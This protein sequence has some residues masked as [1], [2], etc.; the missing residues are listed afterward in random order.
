MIRKAIIGGAQKPMAAVER[1]SVARTLALLFGFGGLLLLF[2]VLLPPAGSGNR[3][4]AALVAVALLALIV[5]ACLTISRDRTPFWLMAVAPALGSLLVGAV[6][7]F[8]GHG[9]AEAYAL[10]F[11]WVVIAAATFL[12][13]GATALHGAF[14]V[15]V[16]DVAVR[17]A[18]PHATPSA[19]SLA[20]LAGT[21]FVAA[22]VLA[23]VAARRRAFVAELQDAAQT[24]PLTGLANRRALRETFERELP[25]AER[26]RRPLALIVLDIDHFKRFN[27]ALGHPAG[28]DA[29]RRL[30]TIL[31]EVTRRSELAAR[32]GGEEFAIVAPETDLAGA[33]ALSERI[34]IAVETEFADARPPLTVSFGIAIHH[35]GALS[36]SDLFAAADRALYRAKAEGRNRIAVAARP[37]GRRFQ[38]PGELDEVVESGGVGKRVA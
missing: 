33:M 28:D 23:G 38:R 25:R 36:S 19:L 18:G 6:I 26:T 1:G 35:P 32:T 2:T 15:A 16:Y 29:L 9:A 31:A 37:S 12:G 14:A 11:A 4:E 27:D 20:M 22:V 17:I 13:R 5:C 7:C 3:D 10:Y 8:A 21:A 34:R 24:D 30:S